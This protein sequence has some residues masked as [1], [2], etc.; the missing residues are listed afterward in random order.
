M[1]RYALRDDQW[2]RIKDLLPGR[3]CHVGVTA[4]DNRL[5]NTKANHL[6]STKH[7]LWSGFALPSRCFNRSS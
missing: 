3:E 6:N 5:L 7:R 1:R 4:R 2:D